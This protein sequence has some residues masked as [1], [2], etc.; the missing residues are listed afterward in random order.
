MILKL[1]VVAAVSAAGLSLFTFQSGSGVAPAGALS[2]GDAPG[3]APTSPGQQAGAMIPGR[4]L[5]CTLG[6]IANFDASRVQ[7]PSEYVFEGRHEFSLYLPAAPVRTTPPPDPVDAPE[8]VD[9]QTRIIADPDGLA[10]DSESSPFNRVVDVWPQR[11]EMT[12]PINSVSVTLIII[13]VTD[14]SQSSASM[15]LTKANDAATFDLQNLYSGQC[16]VTLGASGK[17]APS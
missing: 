15:F 9:P 14:Q 3:V 6:R 4:R 16:R 11:V 17:A 12:K 7:E 1:G 2:V 5:D 13:E 10:K 8:P